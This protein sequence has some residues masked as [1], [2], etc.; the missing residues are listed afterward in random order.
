MIAVAVFLTREAPCLRGSLSSRACLLCDC[1]YVMSL[2]MHDATMMLR[3]SR[4]CFAMPL[5][6]A[7][8]FFTPPAD[9]LMLMRHALLTRALRFSFYDDAC[10]MLAMSAVEARYAMLPR[11]AVTPFLFTA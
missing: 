4:R 3:A 8:I 1:R 5:P 11:Y 10:R 7:M 6:A 9:M 2:Q